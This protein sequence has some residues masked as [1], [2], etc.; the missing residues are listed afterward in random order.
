MSSGNPETRNRILNA[1]WKLLEAN[2]T[3]GVRMTDIAKQARIS[4]QALYLHFGKRSELLIATTR[5]IDEVKGVDARL[6]PSRTVETGIERLD[7]FI[8][9]WGNYIPEIYGVAKALLAM[10]DSDAAAALAWNDRMQAVRHG[11][12]AAIR[13]L[14]S[15]GVLSPDHTPEQATDILWTM[16][17]VHNWEQLTIECAWSQMKYIETTKSLARRILVAVHHRSL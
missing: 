17:S 12:E 15:D 6:A 9:A 7:A 13:A 14:D 11:C 16:L 4:R 10:K 5:Y 2:Q 1:A 8:D 3:N